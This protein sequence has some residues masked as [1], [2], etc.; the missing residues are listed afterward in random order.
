MRRASRFLFSLL[1]VWSAV[2][3]AV[4]ALVVAG[5]PAWADSPAN[6]CPSSS[7]LGSQLSP[8][9]PTSF[10]GLARSQTGAN[11]LAWQEF[12]A[13][14]WLADSAN[15]GQP[16]PAA[17]AADF[18]TPGEQRPSVWES[19]LDV[20]TVFNHALLP[21][22]QGDQASVQQAARSFWNRPRNPLKPL[23]QL[24]HLGDISLQ[25]T[26]YQQAEG[27]W[28][29]DQRSNLTYYEIRLNQ[30]EYEFIT[31]NIFDGQDLTTYAGQ[32]ACATQPGVNGRG[33]FNLPAGNNAGNQDTD[34]RG[35]AAS[36]GQNIGSI[37]LKASWIPLPDDGS[38]NERYKIAKAEVVA[39]DGGKKVVTV[40]LVG[41]HVIHK[42]PGAP[43]FTW[44]TFEQIDNS[45][46]DNFGKPAAPIL[47][48]N[49]NQKPRSGFAFFNP[50][51]SAADDRPGS[52]LPN[53]KP[54]PPCSANAT[55]G[56]DCALY[57]TPI[58]VTRMVPVDGVANAVTAYAWSLMPADSV[59]NYYRLIDVQWP[60]Q[61]M[62]V[63]PGTTADHMPG[64]DITPSTQTRVVANTTMETYV[65]DR[66]ACMSCHQSAPIA[67]PEQQAR[68][69]RNGVR[70]RIV[71]IAQAP[72][73]QSSLPAADYSFI[74]AGHAVS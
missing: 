70:K 3:F 14:N 6:P 12:I 29:T 36:Y 38:L 50:D 34:C 64:G 19:Y 63:K 7:L 32:L 60:N 35:I 71:S 43:Q 10:T 23:V 8:A 68:L 51:C 4:A 59:F 65:Q 13:L 16:D 17:S 69:L 61:P 66:L 25:L 48:L 18:G 26:N 21:M 40:G 31:T 54:D 33:G 41:L 72:S 67:S 9:M 42:L 30:D 73:P 74:F 20:G 49:P 11:C 44:A 39:P 53:H 47:P 2:C 58:Q 62:A 56:A 37:E 55:S 15:P 52:C 46:D 22:E 45:P 1:T 5:H 28:L 57:T 27:G 24:S